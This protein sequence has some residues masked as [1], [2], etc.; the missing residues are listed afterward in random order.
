MEFNNS[1]MPNRSQDEQKV[2]EI[3]QKEKIEFVKIEFKAKVPEKNKQKVKPKQMKQI[4][5][6]KDS[7][8][9][10]PIP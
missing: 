6:I 10:Q 7:H 8:D 3:P 4:I 9:K 1:T 5:A 2:V